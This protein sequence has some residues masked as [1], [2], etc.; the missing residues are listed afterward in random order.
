[1]EQIVEWILKYVT[2]P[3]IGAIIGYCTNYIAVKMLFLPKKE[4]RFMGRRLPFTPGAI[5]R[6]K[7]RLAKA[8]GQVVGNTLIT[9]DDI[10]RNLLSE[11][12]AK[13]IASSLKKR[14]SD[15]VKNEI[16]SLT[17]LTEQEYIAKRNKVVDALSEEITSSLTEMHLADVIVD[18]GGTVVKEKLK[19]SML[20]MFLN[21]ERIDSIMEPLGEE[22]ETLLAENGMDYIYP[23]VKEKIVK[24][25]R[26]SGLALL[27]MMDVSSE[28]IDELVTSIYIKAINAGVGKLMHSVDIAGIVETKINDM[29]IETMEDM[30]LNVM[31][32][33]LNMIVN[34]GAL[35]GLLLGLINILI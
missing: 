17:D 21:D 26:Q 35:I 19:G 33:E 34:L 4:I 16:M 11:R 29:S 14:L 8:V 31:K 25:E 23:V 15:P 18:K 20:K 10:A 2:G 30:V 27:E 12:H 32:K 5:P 13:G 28:D 7:E 22:F 3:L 6:G 9:Q 1:M 24:L